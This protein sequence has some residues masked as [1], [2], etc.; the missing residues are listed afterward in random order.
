MW[1]RIWHLLVKEFLTLFKDKRSRFV[2]IAPPLVQLLVFGY[3]ATFDID[4]VPYAVYDE[5]RGRWSQAVLARLRGSPVFEEAAHLDHDAQIA[6]VLD[7]RQ[8]L[9]VIHFGSRFSERLARGR[10]APVQVILDGR[11]SNTA[12]I[13]LGYLR[14]VLADFTVEH[15]H[16]VPPG[17]PVIRAWFNENLQ[18]RWFIVPGIVALL[19][20][21]V[22]M[23]TTALTVAREREQGT[24]DQLL[25]TPITPFEILVGKTIPPFVI[26]LAEGSL[27]L[28]V[29]VY[30]FG[31]PFRGSL[32]LFYAGM[33]LYLLAAIGVGL[34]I[35]SL[36]V[37]QQQGL[38][39]AFLF[40]VPAVI[41]SGFA[42]PIENMPETVQRITY[43]NPMRYFL[44]IVRTTFLADPP[45]ALLW[46]QFWPMAIIAAVTL[47]AAAW[48]F[49][50]RLY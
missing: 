27:I 33:G 45:F 4:R 9:F 1:H 6:P 25:V 2:V 11:N 32:T 48:L 40:V 14:T 50:H 38:M 21:V 36:S 19:T 22:T 5:D 16:I 44:V 7:R 18:S 15:L 35:S 12:L 39:G 26:G 49:R 42:T 23:V 10:Q 46:P 30:W 13:V 41:L 24:F 31:V 28:A 17:R 20:L 29:A 37:T 43:L 3:A 47:A 34:M 8:V